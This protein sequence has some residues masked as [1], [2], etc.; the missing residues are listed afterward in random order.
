ML[1]DPENPIVRLCAEGMELE[2]KQQFAEAGRLFAK[3]WENATTDLEKFIAAHYVAR[4]QQSVSDKLKWDETALAFALQ[5]RDS[6]MQANYP[7][8]YLNIAKC[9]EDLDEISSARNHYELALSY[10]QYLPDNGYG[11]IILTGIRN[12]I[13]R[14]SG[15]R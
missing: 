15:T 2:L 4:H 8:L 10:S 14:L 6:G 3:A 9:Y 7:S 12:G 13:E 1:F 5:I 11:Q